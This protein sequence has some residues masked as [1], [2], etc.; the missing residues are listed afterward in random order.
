MHE[1]FPWNLSF[2]F[3]FHLRFYQTGFDELDI[4]HHYYFRLVYQRMPNPYTEIHF[5]SS[6]SL[7]SFEFTGGKCKFCIRMF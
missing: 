3:L 7:H 2:P 4:L 5:E 6:E 1:P